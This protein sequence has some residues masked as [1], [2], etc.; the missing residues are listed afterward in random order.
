M[1][2]ERW[3]QIESIFQAVLQ[4]DGAERG[5]YLAQALVMARWGTYIL[6]WIPF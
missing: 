4:H 6:P 5:A 3:Q 2:P 1:D